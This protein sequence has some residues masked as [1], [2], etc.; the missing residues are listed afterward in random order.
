MPLFLRSAA[1]AVLFILG[2]LAAVNRL[3][4]ATAGDPFPLWPEG[5]P[6]ALGTSANDVP[7][8]TAYLP[9]PAK[10]TGASM[11]ILP[12]GGYGALAGHEGA[13][14]AEWLTEQGIACY[15]LQY[16]LGSHGYRHPRML[17]DAARGL[18]MVRALARR[19]GL[20]HGVIGGRT[21]CLNAPHPV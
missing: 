20:G 14:Y 2:F 9:D 15:V 5:A 8:L 17:E 3:A 16:R 7:K 21:S 19:D 18:R 10:R 4:A 11:L 13:G 1:H 12:G 6:G